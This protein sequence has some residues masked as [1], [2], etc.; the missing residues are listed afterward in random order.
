MLS[1]YHICFV[2]AH[3]YQRIKYL[4]LH[5]HCLHRKEMDLHHVY[6]DSR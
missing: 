1:R 6:L 3:K 4:Q 2:F 5:H